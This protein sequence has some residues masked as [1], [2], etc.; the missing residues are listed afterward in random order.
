[1]NINIWW[2]VLIAAPWLLMYYW[3]DSNARAWR[4][5]YYM[6]CKERDLETYQRMTNA[7]H[8]FSKE[9]LEWDRLAGG[10]GKP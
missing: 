1:M 9:F 7:G 4:K 2:G 10:E 3:A 6:A 5:L 8:V